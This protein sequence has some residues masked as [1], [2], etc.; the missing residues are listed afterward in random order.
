MLLLF[1]IKL[2]NKIVLKCIWSANCLTYILDVE[3]WVVWACVQMLL[4][5]R[6][7]K[8][9]HSTTA[10]HKY[11]CLW[12]PNTTCIRVLSVCPSSS[13]YIAVFH[14][15]KD[16]AKRK[17]ILVRILSKSVNSQSFKCLYSST[18]GLQYWIFT[19]TCHWCCI[20]TTANWSCTGQI[21]TTVILSRSLKLGL[22]QQ[23]QSQQQW[24][25]EPC[26][27]MDTTGPALGQ[28]PCYTVTTTTDCCWEHWLTSQT[29]CS[30]PNPHQPATLHNNIASLFH[31]KLSLIIISGKYWNVWHRRRMLDLLGNCHR[32]S[33][34]S[35]LG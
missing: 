29:S 14:H 1:A 24:E 34:G 9:A 16:L 28:E 22:V 7:Y 26:H 10:G 20:V 2:Q 15:A 23:S 25:T 33:V 13:S 19:L 5:W 35:R 21:C 18:W 31:M 6:R 32:N 30:G 8:H 11:P 12:C 17:R 3:T 4:W 27:D